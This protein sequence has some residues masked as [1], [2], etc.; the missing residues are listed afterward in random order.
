MRVVVGG[1]FPN[2]QSTYSIIRQRKYFK[3]MSISTEITSLKS[4]CENCQFET[5]HSILFKKVLRSQSEE[6]NCATI[7][8]T[9]QCM[10]CDSISFRKEFHDFFD[11]FPDD[12]GNWVYDTTLTLF[13]QTLKNHKDF[14]DQHLLPDKIQTVYNESLEAIKANCRLLAGVGF[15]AVVEAICIDKAITGRSLELKINN[16]L[17]SR[18]ITDKEAERLHAVRFMG[19][20]SVHEMAVPNENAL[21]VVLEIIEHLLNNLYIIDNHAK[22]VIDGIITNQN[23]F[24]KLLLEKLY[25]YKKDDD[26]PLAKFLSKDVRRLNGQINNFEVELK[27]Q[28]TSSKFTKLKIGDVKNFGTNPSAPSQHFI[29]I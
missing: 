7:Y 25:Y 19:N 8:L 29:V 5:N 21:Y 22:K 1:R 10:G 13:P 3:T 24:E 4:Y 9:V 28:I 11:A 12:Y 15:R 23:E 18:F 6:Y 26:F 14:N 17:K 2:S 16:L 27:N 20:D